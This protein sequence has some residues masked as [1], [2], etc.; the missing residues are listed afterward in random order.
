ML[1][2]KIKDFQIYRWIL[3]GTVFSRVY[4]QK[5]KHFYRVHEYV[6]KFKVSLS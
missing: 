1:K 2:R 5:K 6:K 4:T 3:Y